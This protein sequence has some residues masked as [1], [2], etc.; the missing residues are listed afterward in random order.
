[1]QLT[2]VIP[3]TRILGYETVTYDYDRLYSLA[4]KLAW[5]I[6]ALW[7]GLMVTPALSVQVK[8]IGRK[9]EVFIIVGAA[10]MKLLWRLE[11][12]FKDT[13]KSHCA[14]GFTLSGMLWTKRMGWVRLDCKR[15][16]DWVAITHRGN[17]YINC[18][19]PWYD[20]IVIA[21]AGLLKWTK[22]F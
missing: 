4:K 2:L 6:S 8:V 20:L 16:L 10:A 9:W 1:M 14:Y 11:Q 12:F 21:L 13:H 18:V 22:H 3:R 7:N 15:L 5:S 17:G 19:G